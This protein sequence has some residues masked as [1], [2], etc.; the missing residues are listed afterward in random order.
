MEE[1]L[2]MEII[3]NNF[4][5]VRSKKMKC[6][7]CKSK[8]RVTYDDLN[9]HYNTVDIVTSYYFKCP[10]CKEKMELSL[11]KG[12]KLKKLYFGEKQNEKV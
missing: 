2:F 3:K 11:K 12:K 1:N 7:H 9:M 5:P 4:N 10:C 6:K 8:F